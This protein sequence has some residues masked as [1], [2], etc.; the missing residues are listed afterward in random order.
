MTTNKLTNIWIIAMAI[1]LIWFGVLIRADNAKANDDDSK[2]IAE[3]EYQMNELRKQKDS[4]FN[5][6]TY[7]ES[8]SAFQWFTKPCVSRDEEIMR[9]REKAD[10]LKAKSYEVGLK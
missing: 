4:C 5:S 6:L 1:L 8:I 10:S 2:Q 3:L 9:L 7:E